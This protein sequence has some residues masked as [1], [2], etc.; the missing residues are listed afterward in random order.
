VLG[1]CGPWRDGSESEHVSRSGARGGGAHRWA[2]E[3]RKLAGPT[4]TNL[5]T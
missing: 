3:S 5:P 1:S 2:V 4:F